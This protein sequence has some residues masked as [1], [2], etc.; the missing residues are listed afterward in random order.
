MPA[1]P[2]GFAEANQHRLECCPIDNRVTEQT[3][4]GANRLGPH[5]IGNLSESARD[6]WLQKRQKS[7]VGR[8]GQHG[9]LNNSAGLFPEACRPIG[10]SGDLS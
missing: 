7:C 2:I 5:K 4:H 1:Q 8:C 6:S 3:G 9:L 10:Q